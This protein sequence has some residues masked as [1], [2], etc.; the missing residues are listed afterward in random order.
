[1]RI[2]RI[3][4]L[5]PI[6]HARAAEEIRA[7][8]GALDVLIN[9]AGIYIRDPR[10]APEKTHRSIRLFNATSTLELLRINA[11][12]PLEITRTLLPLLLRVDHLD[13]KLPRIAFISS[14]MA[15]IG[16]KNGAE[17]EYGYSGSK[18]ALNMFARVLAQE[19]AS[20]GILVALLSPGWV[21][22]D[23]GTSHAP[24]Q[25]AVVAEGLFN[26]IDALDPA[27]S[28]SFLTW[29]GQPLPW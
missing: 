16:G 26:V 23:M 20:H 18:A 17:I 9:N 5:D 25:P 27:T 13:K 19:L 10:V 14:G 8:A 28:G 21:A 1:L 29:Q 3:D 6:T 2:V 22:T 24:L 11:V 7:Q 12:A 15:S 4:L